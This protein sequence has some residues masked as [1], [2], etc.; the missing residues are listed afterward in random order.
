MQVVAATATMLAPYRVLDLTDGRAEL[1]TFVLAGFGADVV[2]VEP[3]RGSPSRLDGPPAGDEPPG[4]AS[5]R[6]HAFNRGKRSIV[7]DLEE[8]DGRRQFLTL[9]SSA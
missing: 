1:A 5:L 6:F 9:V 3:P 8:A 4:L 7:V 2:K